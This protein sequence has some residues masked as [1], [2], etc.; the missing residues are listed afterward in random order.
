MLKF[1]GDE[2][3]SHPWTLVRLVQASE[4]STDMKVVGAVQM[5]SQH[6]ATHLLLKLQRGE[7]GW[8]DLKLDETWDDIEY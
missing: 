7:I 5:T 2:V 3:A 1:D 4:R 8:E 6:S